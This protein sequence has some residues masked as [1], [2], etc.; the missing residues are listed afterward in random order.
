MRSASV[1]VI[2]LAAVFVA[3]ATMASIGPAEAEKRKVVSLTIGRNAVGFHTSFANKQI[4]VEL[5]GP[6]VE[7]DWFALE[8]MFSSEKRLR[9]Y[10]SLG[11]TSGINNAFAVIGKDGGR[12]VVIGTAF[13]GHSVENMITLGHEVGHHICGHTIRNTSTP[14]EM[15]LEADRIS[16]VGLRGWVRNGMGTLNDIVAAAYRVYTN[17]NG[18]RSHPPQNLRVA[19]I[20]NGYNE[21]TSPCFDRAVALPTDPSKAEAERAAK[22]RA[23]QFCKELVSGFCTLLAGTPTGERAGLVHRYGIVT[24]HCRDAGISIA[25]VTYSAGYFRFQGIECSGRTG[26]IVAQ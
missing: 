22:V 14:W 12:Y 21:G 19:A 3:G 6:H 4:W 25:P 24:G 8:D 7:H 16:G 5:D 11:R 18:T 23:E 9:T 17:I 15:E 10:L 20:L 1:R 13:G 2:S 26:R